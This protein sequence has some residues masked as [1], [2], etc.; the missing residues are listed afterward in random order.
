MSTLQGV[1][2]SA[3]H[4][5]E[6]QPFSGAPKPTVARKPLRTSIPVVLASLWVGGLVVAAVLAQVLPLPA[7]DIAAGPSKLAPFNE[8]GAL[9]LGTDR[10][11]R[12]ELSRVI[13]GARSSLA[14]GLMATAVGMILGT[15]LGLLS[16]YF[17][18]RVDTVIGTFTNMIL[19]LPGLVLLLAISS[20]FT[21]SMQSLLIGLGLLS[22]PTFVR[23]SRASTMNF[24][25]REFVMAARSLGASHP[26]ILVRELLPNILLPVLSY[27]FILVAVLI[28]AE[29]ALSYLGVGVPP[30]APSW[31]GMIADGQ[32][33]LRTNPHLLAIPGIAMFLTIFAL[34]TLG[35]HA[36]K[37]VNVREVKQ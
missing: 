33:D 30:P 6:Q 23:I 13:Y 20:V 1:D 7:P 22:I 12:S 2:R 15:I 19:A 16:G 25:S 9:L 8:D 34:N 35:D 29:G 14:I 31:G 26:R 17:R 5:I 18:G 37:F 21:P 3:Q 24:A 10:L 4:A 27:A 28:A 32:R 36:R 11:G